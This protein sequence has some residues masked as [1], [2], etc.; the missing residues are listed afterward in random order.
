MD[1]SHFLFLAHDCILVSSKEG[2]LYLVHLI[3]DGKVVKKIEV[4]RAGTSV[5]TSC[6]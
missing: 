5:L 3:A 2:E 6:V 1:V 4:T